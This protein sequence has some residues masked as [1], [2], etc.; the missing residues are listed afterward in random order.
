VVGRNDT[1]DLEAQIRGSRHAWDVRI[2]SSEALVKLVELKVKSD[3]DETV[4]KIRSLLVPFEYTRL[5]NIIDVMFSTA[6]DVEAG[7]EEGKQASDEEKAT[8]YGSEQKQEH[9]PRAILE[10]ARTDAVNAVGIMEGVKFIAHKRVQFWSS[11]KRVRVVCP[12][13]KPYERG[14]YWYG[15]SPRQCDFLAEGERSFLVLGCVDHPV[16]F[17]LPFGFI[18]PLLP[19]LNFTDKDGELIHW[20]LQVDFTENGDHQLLV[21]KREERISLKSYE[22]RLGHEAVIIDKIDAPAP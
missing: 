10:K 9:T 19:Y 2:I 6:K 22:L 12:I 11:D 21:P 1:G 16:A 13:S 18:S 8:D 4:R 7:A 14:Y 15:L 17:A 5:D 20:H 3:E